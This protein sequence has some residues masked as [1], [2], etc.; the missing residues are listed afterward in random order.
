MGSS[1]EESAELPQVKVGDISI[2]AA[3]TNRVEMGKYDLKPHKIR[4]TRHRL[5]LFCLVLNKHNNQ[6]KRYLDAA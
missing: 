1:T 4:K 6:K 3:I 2:Q 5:R